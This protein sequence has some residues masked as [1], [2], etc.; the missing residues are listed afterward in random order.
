MYPYQPLAEIT[1]SNSSLGSKQKI[2]EQQLSERVADPLRV[3]PVGEDI[4]QESPV[5]ESIGQIPQQERSRV[6]AQTGGPGFH[7]DAAVEF[8]LEERKLRF[9]HG[10]CCGA[11]L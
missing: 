11:V 8:R 5:A 9:T 2:G 3:S 7:P 4:G 10:V 1:L 6:P